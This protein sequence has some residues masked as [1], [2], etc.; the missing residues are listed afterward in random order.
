MKAELRRSRSRPMVKCA[1]VNNPVNSEFL[2]E[3]RLALPE[4]WFAVTLNE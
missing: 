4:N 2:Q 1:R 3:N